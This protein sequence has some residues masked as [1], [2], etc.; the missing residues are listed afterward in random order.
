MLNRE[1]IAELLHLHQR[2]YQL[3]LWLG[4]QAVHHPE[5]LSPEIMQELM[6]PVACA[7]WLA[8]H[9]SVLPEDGLP[10]GDISDEFANLFS[11]FFSTSFRVEHVSW[12]D[13]LLN[14]T[15]RAG[16]AANSAP[17][18]FVA[19]QALALRHLG[20]SEGIRISDSE[21]R[22]LAKRKS[23]RQTLLLWTY[24]W[25]LGRRAKGKGK[26]EIV[27]RIWRSLPIDVRKNLTVEAIWE[28]RSELLKH[29]TEWTAS[30]GSDAS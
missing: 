25:E 3:V 10:E 22:T 19:A 23:M 20:G 12:N 11:S 14:T 6:K 21:A 27:H 24:V 13:E 9:R 8:S 15:L 7:A 5:M 4:Q 2:T 17:T 18:G 29:L 30:Q 1:E 28:A 16:P 26:G